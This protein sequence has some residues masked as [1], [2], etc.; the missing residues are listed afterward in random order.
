MPLQVYQLVLLTLYKN[1]NYKQTNKRVSSAN[2]KKGGV[3]GNSFKICIPV[4]ID[5]SL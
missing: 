1:N 3:K 2:G 5:G 4:L